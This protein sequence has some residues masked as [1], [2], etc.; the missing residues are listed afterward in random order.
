[1]PD[2]NLTPIYHITYAPSTNAV[3]LFFWGCNMSCRGCYCQRRIYSTMLGDYVDHNLQAPR[4]LAAPPARFLDYQE[5]INILDQVEVKEVTL[6]GQEATIYP[7][8]SQL[9]AELH[10]RYGSFNILLTNGLRL[11]E[12]KDTDRVGFGLKA[13][14]ESLHRRYTGIDNGEIIE[15]L[16]EIHRRNIPLVVES[17]YIP[18]FIDGAETEL[19]AQY[20][21][22]LDKDTGYIILPYFQ[23]G[24]NPWRRPLP[25]EMRSAGRTAK[26]YLKNV[27]FFTGEEK[28]EYEVVSLFPTDIHHGANQGS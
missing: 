27:L 18:D 17:V 26:Q 16:E 5:V 28:L 8:Y 25:D 3:S 1:M 14:T 7:G 6:E 2:S 13:V 22:S 10:R 20:L 21:A 12:L 19:I 23:A 24:D 9:T 11:P 4:G 15:H